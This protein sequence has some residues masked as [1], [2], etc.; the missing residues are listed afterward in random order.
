VI[1]R[2][3][4]LTVLLAVL[5]AFTLAPAASA[6]VTS[7]TI[8]GT[9]TDAS[10]AAV[11]GASVTARNV[12]TGFSRTVTSDGVGAYRLEFLPIGGYVVEVTLS[13]FKTSNRSGIVLRV[14]DTVRVD[15]SLSLGDLA[16]TVTVEGAAPMVNTATADVSKTIEAVEIQSLPL[17]DR[18]V[19]TLLD[20]TPG[21][22]SNNNGVSSAST[23][24]SS[25]IL[26]FPEQRTQINGGADGGTG[27]VNYYLDGGINMTGLRNTG[28]ILPNPDAIQE[29]KVQTNSYNVEYGRFSSGI[30]NVITKSGTNR[31][32]GSAFEYLRDESL[33]AKDWGSQL[34]KAPLERNQFG[35]SIGGPIV[36][37]RTFF[38]L[39]Y[40]G[41]RQETSTFLNT[42]IV[43]TALERAGNFSESR[44]IPTDPATGQLFACGGV[45]GF[46]CPDRFDPVAMRILKDYIPESNVPGNIWQGYVPSPYDTDEILVK[47]DHQLNDAHRLT[48]AYFLT[49]GENTVRAGGGNLP[50]AEQQFKWT[51][52]N[53]NLS[54]TWMINPTM[55][56]QAWFSYTRNYG[57]RLNVPAI[58]LADLGSSFIPQGAPSLPQIT[59]SGYFSLTNSI[60]G[61]KA[62]GDFYSMRDVFS[63]TRGAHAIKLGGEVSYNKTVQDTLL[64]N[65]GVYTF[66]SNVSKNA[67]ADFMLGI[68]SNVTQDAPVTALWNSW[69]GA[70]FAQDEWRIGRGLT[71]SLGVRWDVQTPGTDPQNRFTTYVPGQQS[72]VNPAAPVG[73]LFYGDPGVERGVISTSWTH[74]SPRAGI[75]WDPFGDGKT[76][77]RAAA[78]MF[79]GS[80][81]GNEFNTSTNFQPWST[82]LTFANVNTKTT[83]T[84]APL[85]ATLR[86]PYYA[87]PGG[88][89]FPYQGTYAV[90]GGLFGISQDFVW[91]R[92]YQTNVGIQRQVT[93]RLVLGAAYIGTFHRNLPFGRDVNYPVVTPTATNSGANILARRPNPKVGAVTLLDSDQWSN[94]HGL[95]VTFGLR[96]WHHISFNGFY[97]LSSTRSSAQ[98][99]NNTTQGLAQNYSR[100][101]DEHGRA[102]TDQRH[103]FSMSLNWE[104]EYYRGG[105]ALLR[106]ILN[107]W[108]ISPIIKIRSGLPFTI[109][110][111]S[112]DANLDGV[113]NDRAQQVG[114]W[115]IDD[116][117]PARWFNTAAFVQ[118]KVVTGVAT[119]GNSPRNLVDGPGFRVVDLAL[120]RDF[121]LPRGMRLIF[122]AEATNAFN[123]VNYGQ[124]GAAVPSGATSTTFGVIRTA[125]AMRR[126][127]LG[128]RLTF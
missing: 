3:A 7:A 97:T 111:G 47:L 90:G 120:S 30:I 2:T 44:T 122:R 116:P 26:G 113:T 42:A 105:S 128:A 60:G 34:G 85:G 32:K 75:V 73:Q 63:W 22:Q 53:V 6:Q 68:P 66:N 49:G 69:Y 54:D 106:N 107:G 11:P 65:Y 45:V 95:Q 50:W 74:I 78:G 35:G 102:D 8:V 41:L 39:S 96:P 123:V 46:I 125:N 91:P 5:T 67:L 10:N 23:G 83:S 20:L 14:N 79:Y 52:H 82:R 38:F 104:L 76:S 1:N 29:F 110:N 109:T 64:N 55:I 88:T 119:N 13:G 100:L 24:T 98:L 101:Q 37:D 57:G 48:G 36:K 81:S 87:Y 72:V 62:G 19:Y 16:E 80:I 71:L 99:H 61:P 31:F 58:S 124:P 51:Q 117:T 43:P 127:Q 59:V 56:N 121:R 77:I 33:N 12:D 9:V 70:L 15:V 112:V 86:D 21:V 118:N 18:N 40:S 108:T 103:V 93:S 4:F 115:Q 84:G 25:L 126:M 27:S 17:V 92:A 28:N 89:P 114:D 94:Y